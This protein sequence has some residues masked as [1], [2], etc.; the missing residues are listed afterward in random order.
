MKFLRYILSLLV[1]G[2]MAACNNDDDS[3]VRACNGTAILDSELFVSAPSQT[4][5]INRAE[6][7][8]DCLEISFS[9]NG[10]NGDTFVVNLIGAPNDVAVFPPL[11]NVRLTPESSELCEAIVNREVS[12]DLLVFQQPNT[13]RLTLS[14]ENNGQNLIYRY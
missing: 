6:I 8:G 12:F 13:N 3:G 14:L 9:A 4:L 1:F 7:E 11:T 5:T 10:C 2:L